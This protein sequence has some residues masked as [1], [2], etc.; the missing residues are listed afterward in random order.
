MGSKKSLTCQTMTVRFMRQYVLL[1]LVFLVG[2]LA[3]KRNEFYSDFVCSPTNLFTY[4]GGITYSLCRTSQ[5][6]SRIQ[7][8]CISPQ[9]IA[10]IVEQE[11]NIWKIKI[12]PDGT[13]PLNSSF[14]IEV[15]ALR[16][17]SLQ[18]S[19]MPLLTIRKFQLRLKKPE[20]HI[21]CRPGNELIFSTLS[22]KLVCTFQNSF[23]LSG[24]ARIACRSPFPWLQ[25]NPQQ[26]TYSLL[27]NSELKFT[28]T[29]TYIRRKCR[30]ETGS[31]QLQLSLPNYTKT[32]NLSARCVRGSFDVICNKTVFN[33]PDHIRCRVK[34]RN[35][36]QDRIH[37]S[38]NKKSIYVQ[39]DMFVLHPDGEVTVHFNINRF[40]F[41]GKDCVDFPIRVYFDAETTGKSKSVTF[42]P[43]PSLLCEY[44]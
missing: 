23:P 9:A 31:I 21:I 37:V 4:P 35:L 7:V 36:F 44:N 28:T 18:P 5:D 3:C 20:L 30:N 43:V 12:Q 32:W 40:V 27:N 16:K 38:L 41:D 11:K 42:H 29:L 39:P 6:A 15:R 24:E 10:C 26:A 19:S 14:Q 1:L 13:L 22:L 17:A 34:S 8:T 25:C 2:S 33:V